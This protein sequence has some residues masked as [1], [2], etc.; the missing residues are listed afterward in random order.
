MGFY[1]V[2]ERWKGLG[3]G[4]RIHGTFGTPVSG[5]AG[6]DYVFNYYNLALSLKYYP[7][8]RQFNQGLYTRAS[9]GFGQMTTKR[10]NEQARSYSHQ[11]AIGSTL[12]GSIGY[13]FPLKKS[14]IS[15]EGHFEYSGRNGTVDTQGDGV[16]FTSGQIGGNIILSF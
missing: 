11:Y 7:F 3:I 10:L 4:S 2:P 6:D 5:D 1:V 14:A 15:L 9:V 16:R 8:S 13:S 12:S